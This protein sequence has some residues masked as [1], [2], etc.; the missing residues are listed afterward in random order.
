[1]RICGRT[2]RP[3]TLAER[4]VLLALGFPTIRVPRHSN[5][6]IVARRV[7]R[8]A[9]GNTDDHQFLRELVRAQHKAVPPSPEPEPDTTEPVMPELVPVHASA[10]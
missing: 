5:P 9:K 7:S 10:A 1:M 8:L 2:L 4:R 3:S 6:F